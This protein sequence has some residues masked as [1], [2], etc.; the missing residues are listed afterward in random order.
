MRKLPKLDFIYINFEK[1]YDTWW[2]KNEIY[3]NLL[4]EENVDDKYHF[5]DYVKS[6]SLDDLIYLFLYF[7]IYM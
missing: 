7:F 3:L 1:T 5:K 2:D 4:G 6:C